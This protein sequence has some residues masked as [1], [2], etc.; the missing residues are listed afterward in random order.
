MRLVQHLCPWSSPHIAGDCEVLEDPMNGM[1]TVDGLSV[2]STATYECDPGF[3]LIGS[4]QRFCQ[5]DGIWSGTPSI[6]IC[7]IFY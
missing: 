6:C 3:I 2:G 4:E 1:V 5:E 7:K